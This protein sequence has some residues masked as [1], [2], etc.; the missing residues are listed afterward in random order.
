MD[1]ATAVVTYRTPELVRRLLEAVEREVRDFSLNI[2][3][4]VVDNASG[5]DTLKRITRFHPRTFTVANPKNQGPAVGFNLAVDETLTFAPT[6]ILVT[7]R[8]TEPVSG[9]LFRM[10]KFLEEHRQI[11]GA[12]NRLLNSDGSPQRQRL[13]I[14]PQAFRSPI[15]VIPRRLRPV[16]GHV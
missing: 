2:R 9:S 12:T 3:P 11:D 13:S 5:D 16:S 15:L 14:Y 8:D 6:Y 4:V 1:I 7:N 10:F